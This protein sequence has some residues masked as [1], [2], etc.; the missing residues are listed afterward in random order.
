MKI[1]FLDI[2]GVLNSFRHSEYE[3]KIKKIKTP[4]LLGIDQTALGILKKIVDETGANI[5]ISSTWRKGK[6]VEFFVGLFEGLGWKNA[7]ILSCTATVGHDGNRG[8]EILEWIEGARRKKEIS[9][10][11]IDDET[12]D[13]QDIHKS[14]I[15]QTSMDDGLLYA[16]ALEAIEILGKTVEEVNS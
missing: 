12:S 5:V 6:T 13:M 14:L 8:R 16:D 10:I 3:I 7:P 4:Y 9:Y 1:I 15:I 11:V 2:D